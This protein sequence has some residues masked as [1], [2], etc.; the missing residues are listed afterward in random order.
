MDKK[1]LV[2]F[3][4]TGFPTYFELFKVANLTNRIK[5]LCS[6]KQAIKKPAFYTFAG[7]IYFDDAETTSITNFDTEVVSGGIF[8]ELKS[9]APTLEESINKQEYVSYLNRMNWLV[10]PL[11]VTPE[12]PA[13]TGLDSKINAYP[14]S[15]IQKAELKKGISLFYA[16]WPNAEK[17]VDITGTRPKVKFET[18]GEK[19]EIDLSNKVMTDFTPKAFPDYF[20]LFKAA[21]L[22]NS[23]KYICKS[24]ETNEGLPY[25]VSSN[26]IA[27]DHK[28]TGSTDII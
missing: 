5:D 3:T 26:D 15:A 4:P 7:S 17:K 13:Y 12:T 27:F 24:K 23:I 10:V 16:Y 18:Y 8:G 22:T 19:T 6:G 11:P 9:I 25:K 28:G 14:I 21:N 20:E 2:G 1:S